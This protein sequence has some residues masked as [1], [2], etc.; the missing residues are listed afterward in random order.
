MRTV[1]V[2]PGTP[3]TTLEA[4]ALA[5]LRRDKM[6]TVGQRLPA[7]LV[8]RHRLRQPDVMLSVAVGLQCR[9]LAF[10]S[11]PDRRGPKILNLK[12]KS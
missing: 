5:R 3:L 10:I 7:D 1:H 11:R 2:T 4:Q 6:L 8:A 12:G 9:G